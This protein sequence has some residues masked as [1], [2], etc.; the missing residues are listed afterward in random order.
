MTTVSDRPAAASGTFAL[1]GDLPVHRLGFGAMQL[2]G[3]VHGI[4]PDAILVDM[5]T[6]SPD[7]SRMLAEA[8][9]GRF[10]D[11]PILAAPV[12][13]LFDRATDTGFADRDIAAV[14]ESVRARR[15]PV[16]T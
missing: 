14:V 4:Q 15:A 1:G 10:V 12:E 13:R 16:P 6:V 8:V 9:A 5:S 11:A 2:T 3:A 7:T